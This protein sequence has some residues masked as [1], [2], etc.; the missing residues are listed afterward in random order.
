MSTHLIWSNKH[1]MWWRP[2][3][4]GY[5]NSLH[6]AGRYTEDEAR[7]ICA[8][9]NITPQRRTDPYTGVPYVQDNEVMILTPV[10]VAARLKTIDTVEASVLG[11]NGN[12]E[13]T[14]TDLIA[15]DLMSACIDRGIELSPLDRDVLRWIS[16]HGAMA[17]QA[18][19][20]LISRASAAGAKQ[21]A[22]VRE[23]AERWVVDPGAFPDGAADPLMQI[24]ELLGVTTRG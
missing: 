10:N 13:V 17:A 24:A 23:L 15:G 12:R 22:E 7:Q 14:P 2:G 8:D 11:V 6:E 16:S 3:R 19:S 18:V 20:D 5:T 9:A 1:G 4:R 21:S